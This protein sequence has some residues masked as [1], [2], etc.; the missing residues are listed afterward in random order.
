MITLRGDWLVTRK[1]ETLKIFYTESAGLQG[2]QISTTESVCLAIQKGAGR[3]GGS[4]RCDRRGALRGAGAGECIQPKEELGEIVFA[5]DVVHAMSDRPCQG[6]KC[7][8]D[9]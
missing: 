6:G 7:Q 2:R 9:V 3:G 8:E 5:G 4:E 1:S